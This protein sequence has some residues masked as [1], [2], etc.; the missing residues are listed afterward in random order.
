MTFDEL[1]RSLRARNDVVFGTGCD[2]TLIRDAERALGVTFR[3]EL[4][5]YLVRF[6]HLELG[7]FE[8]FGLGGDLPQYLSLV[9][10]TQSE[11]LDTG[12][13]IPRNLVPLLND[14]GGNLYCISTNEASESGVFFWD[15][16]RGP[17][18]EPARCATSLVEW[19]VELLH[20]LDGGAPD[21][22]AASHLKPD[23]AR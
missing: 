7:H 3:P 8:L 6:G 1:E 11:R 18:Q 19:L 23:D 9:T 22:Q 20:D 2:Q 13:P 15:H 5:D 21:P 17:G 10:M 4:Q 12:C 16:E 14:G